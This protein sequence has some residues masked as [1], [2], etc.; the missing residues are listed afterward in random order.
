MPLPG[1]YLVG[2]M[3]SK[4]VDECRGKYKILLVEIF[5]VTSVVSEDGGWDAEMENNVV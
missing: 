4:S 3:G 5:K 1:H 2:S